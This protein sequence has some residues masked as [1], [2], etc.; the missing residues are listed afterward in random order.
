MAQLSPR[1]KVT[2]GVTDSGGSQLSISGVSSSSNYGSLPVCRGLIT[3]EAS[4]VDLHSSGLPVGRSVLAAL[5][6]TSL[7]LSLAGARDLGL[8]PLVPWALRPVPP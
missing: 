2:P 6:P 1:L 4:G 3:A 5:C 8:C 7:R